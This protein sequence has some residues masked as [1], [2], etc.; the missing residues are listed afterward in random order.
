MNGESEKGEKLQA[1]VL[2]VEHTDTQSI[3]RADDAKLAELGYRS[4]FRREFSV[5]V[6]QRLYIL[7]DLIFLPN[8][9]A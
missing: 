4:E 1:D 8:A 5:S 9:S 3:I 7:R 6:T 2:T